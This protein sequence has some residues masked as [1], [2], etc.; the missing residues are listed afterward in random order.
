[1]KNNNLSKTLLL[2]LFTSSFINVLHAQ[3]AYTCTSPTCT[4]SASANY[5]N[6]VVTGATAQLVITGSSTSISCSDI[7]VDDG[8][9][10]I[11]TGGARVTTTANT[12]W[13]IEVTNGS[14]LTIDGG[15]NVTTAANINVESW[16]RLNIKEVQ[17][18]I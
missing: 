10:L 5:T 7:I 9:Q 11:I 6:M 15:A 17:S 2:L 4:L 8:A 3:S 1:M 16:C 12:S 18:L 13:N 14:T